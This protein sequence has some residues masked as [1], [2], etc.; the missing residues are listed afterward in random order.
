M[1]KKLL[2]DDQIEYLR[3]IASGRNV[4]VLAQMMNDKF[5]LSLTPA[6]ITGAKSRHGVCSGRVKE[7]PKLRLTTPEQDEYMRAHSK[8]KSGEELIRIMQEQFGITFTKAQMK[9][10]KKRKNINTGLTGCYEKGHVPLNKGRKMSPE[11]YKKAEP[12]MFK[13]GNIPQNYRPVGSERIAADGYVWVKVKDPRTWREKHVIVWEAAYGP[14]PEGH[15]IIFADRN[16]TNF[17]LDNLILISNAECSEIKP[18][19]FNFR[20]S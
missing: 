13:K 11:I 3:Q 1:S 10:Y 9:G 18:T 4:I 20:A 2:S 8:G 16:K 12:T 14:R 17:A 6:Q 5:D 7:Q 15:K 19:S